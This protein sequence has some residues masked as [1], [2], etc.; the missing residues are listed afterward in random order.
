MQNMH[1]DH[2]S[3]RVGVAELRCVK[4]ASHDAVDRTGRKCA[5][6]IQIQVGEELGRKALEHSQ[7]C[8]TSKSQVAAK[9]H[10]PDGRLDNRARSVAH[11]PWGAPLAVLPHMHVLHLCSTMGGA[12]LPPRACLAAASHVTLEPGLFGEFREPLLRVSR[13]ACHPGR[14][15]FMAVL[16]GVAQAHAKQ[17]R[18]THQHKTCKSKHIHMRVT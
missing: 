13:S 17:P 1:S 10:C 8:N 6:A 18:V 7:C 3:E 14:R 15:G 9:R 2:L 11:V 12:A 5:R 16:H 4:Q